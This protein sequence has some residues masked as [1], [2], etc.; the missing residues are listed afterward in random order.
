MV[1]AEKG[2]IL[3][4]VI[5]LWPGYKTRHQVPDD[6]W[7]EQLCSYLRSLVDQRV[8]HVQAWVHSNLSHFNDSNAAIEELRRALD[9]TIVE[10]KRNTHLCKMRCEQCH[11][12]CLGSQFHGEGHDCATNHACPHHCQFVDEHEGSPDICSLVYVSRSL[13]VDCRSLTTGHRA[14]HE[15]VHM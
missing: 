3:R 13:P 7:M 9:S 4:E 14:G 5:R 11:L 1:E 6:E 15:G 12:L 10:L 8:A 2:G